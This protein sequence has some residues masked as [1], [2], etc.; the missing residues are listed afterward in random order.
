LSLDFDRVLE[1]HTA[2]LP[3]N[4]ISTGTI[5]IDVDISVAG[6]GFLAPQSITVAGGSTGVV[7][8]SFLASNVEATG[9]LSLT[10]HGS[11]AAPTI[12][13]LHAIGKRPLVCTPSAPC[14]GVEL[15][16]PARRVRRGRRAR[17][18]PVHA[19]Q[20]LSRERPLPSGRLRRHHP[21]LRRHEQ[22]HR[23]LVLGAGRLRQHDALLPQPDRAVPCGDLRPGLG[24]RQRQRGR[25]DALRPGVVHQ[26]FALLC[27]LVHAGRSARRFSVLAR[28]AMSGAR[29][30][31]GGNCELPDASVMTP[32]FTLP[33]IGKP[34]PGRP[35][36]LAFNGNVY[37]L[38]C[39]V[40]VPPPDGG[41]GDGGLDGGVDAGL[42]GGSDGGSD[43]G[44]DAG[45]PDAGPLLGCV[46]ESFTSNGFRALGRVSRRGHRLARQRERQRRAGGR[47]R[48][49]ELVAIGSG[50]PSWFDVSTTV[51]GNRGHCEGERPV[52]DS[53]VAVD[54]RRRRLEPTGVVER[55]ERGSPSTRTT[56]L[57]VGTRRRH[58]LEPG[59]RRRLRGAHAGEGTAALATAQGA[60]LAGHNAILLVDGGVVFPTGPATRF[61]RGR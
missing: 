9:T 10:A 44:F 13:P 20:P 7:M 58:A 61:C 21:Q 45:A 6:A 22:V 50:S 26:C 29:P 56:P 47:A 4:V 39:G 11:T 49:I 24:L 35:S 19:H 14:K 33:L 57:A 43:G 41:V 2:V 53:A 36:L 54:S 3:L 55:R 15:F 5:S 25:L 60:V 12:V 59:E 42:D 18:E 27:R 1:G 30:L 31:F 51:V 28:D 38:L 34:V 8:V 46:L 23:R 16:A 40:P 48:S 52:A 17:A 32:T 37:F